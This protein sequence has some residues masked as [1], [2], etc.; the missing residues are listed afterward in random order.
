MNVTFIIGPPRSG[1]TLLRDILSQHPDVTAHGEDFHRFHHDL[2][3]FPHR[4]QR[5]DHFR[6]TSVDATPGLIREYRQ[7]VQE[8]IHQTGCQHFLLK[9]STLSIQVDYLR[10]IF[11]K[12]RIIQL[13][14]DGR[15]AACSMEDLRIALERFDEER[16]LGPAPDPLGLWC[17]EHIANKYVRGA[18][19]WAYH[20]T[21]SMLD[22][23]FAG[24]EVFRRFRYE[25]LVQRPVQTVEQILSFMGLT[26]DLDLQKI[27]RAVQDM[28]PRSESLG[29]STCQASG[30]NRIGRYRRELSEAVRCV[31]A[32]LLELPMHL[33][34][35][36]PDPWPEAETFFSSC[37]ELGIDP[38]VWRDK[39]KSEAAWFE[40]Q[41]RAFDVRRLLDI[42]HL[43]PGHKPVLI[44][45]AHLGTSW[46]WSD[47]AV[48]NT[49]S[50]VHKQERRYR[51]ADPQGLW[52]RMARF[53]DGTQTIAQLRAKGFDTDAEAVLLRL[54]QLGFVG[55]IP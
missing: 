49:E 50:F 15:D 6:L 25:D 10:A 9:I 47:D 29:F 34:G 39:A 14:R 44:E 51:F 32:P 53:F 26:A 40:R 5:Q 19:S 30:P 4:T 18:A 3:R 12:A 38:I 46:T 36:V 23:D 8:V 54:V 13:V 24:G 31:V 35:Y 21:R 42:S 16:A 11:P 1:T 33:L 20:V 27:S 7:A 17:A 41:R 48:I 45:G 43:T 28:P 52:P 22:L 37:R 55:L 2:T